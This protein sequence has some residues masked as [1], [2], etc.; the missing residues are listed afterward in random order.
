MDRPTDG[1]FLSFDAFR[2]SVR[3]LFIFG[4]NRSGTTLTSRIMGFHPQVVWIP[5]A[6]HFFTH[7]HELR[8]QLPE[9]VQYKILQ[10]SSGALA[11]ARMGRGGE[12][13]DGLYD[14][15]YRMLRE[16]K[17]SP[18][19]FSFLAYISYRLAGAP[20][21][22]QYWAE[23]SN[24]S[25]A[26]AE[27]LK[28]FYPRCRFVYC[29]RDPRA[30]IASE[31]GAYAKKGIPL[32]SAEDTSTHAALAWTRQV[33]RGV[34]LRDRYPGDVFVSHYE[35]L[36]STPAEQINA[37][38]DFLGVARMP[39]EEIES[40]SRSMGA[41]YKSNTGIDR[42]SGIDARGVDRW[43]QL[44]S[45]EI[46]RNIDLISGATAGRLGYPPAA[47]PAGRRGVLPPRL[48]TERARTYA[49]KW[50][51]TVRESLRREAR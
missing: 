18:E 15:L 37:L 51:F 9:K 17:E 7:F 44:L 27:L 38:W 4:Q 48:G 11:Y 47:A 34:R 50:L 29:V 25:F 5:T 24:S 12:L 19:I 2:T 10:V 8:D 1:E 30:V 3:P 46:I 45:P 32:K 6:T 40:K 28:Q 49:K 14:E 31:L 21:G 35:K 43:T 33:R 13:M 20:A 23:R 39:P 36:V 26:H 16:G 22:V 42:Q 41:I